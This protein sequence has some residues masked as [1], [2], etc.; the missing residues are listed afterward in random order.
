M[1]GKVSF[2]V[3]RAWRPDITGSQ[4]ASRS[5]NCKGKGDDADGARH[6]TSFCFA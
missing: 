1:N 2:K 6:R 4:Q 3:P 5:A